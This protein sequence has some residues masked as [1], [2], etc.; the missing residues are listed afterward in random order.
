MSDIPEGSQGLSRRI[1]PPIGA[2]KVLTHD[3]FTN[4]ILYAE[5]LLD[6]KTVPAHLLAL[7]PLWTR[8]LG[9]M[10]TK[11]KSL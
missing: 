10:G 1:S 4:D 5:H 9:R 11:T 2:T 8:A 3:L 6:L 7:V